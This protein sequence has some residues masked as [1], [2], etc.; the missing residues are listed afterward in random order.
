MSRRTGISIT[1][2]PPLLAYKPHVS[3]HISRVEAVVG[4]HL[5]LQ[6][7]L[8]RLV[9]RGPLMLLLLLLLLRLL[10]LLLL[11]LLLLLRLLLRVK[12]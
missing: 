11:Q 2:V 3:I 7:S 9:H 4:L 12:V 10:L 6:V 8:M 5:V 1:D